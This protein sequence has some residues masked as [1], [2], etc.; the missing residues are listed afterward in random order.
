V[1]VHYGEGIANHT[2]PE[3]CAVYREVCGEALT[4]ER[5]GQVLSREIIHIQDADA[6]AFAE[7]KTDG[8]ANASTRTALRGRRPWHARKL[9]AREPGDLQFDHLHQRGGPHREGEEL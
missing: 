1:Q 8:H 7:G 9:L 3:S 2:G 4:G 5:A 6:V